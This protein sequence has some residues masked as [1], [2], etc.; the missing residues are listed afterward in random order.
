M[1]QTTAYTVQS[2]KLFKIIQ[3]HLQIHLHADDNQIYL[4]IGLHAAC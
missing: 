1:K 2:S 3:K 4:S